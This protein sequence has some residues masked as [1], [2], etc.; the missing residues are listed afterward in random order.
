MK[1][2]EK[3]DLHAKSIAELQ[4]MLLDLKQE[5][6]TMNL[7]MAQRKLTN[8]RSRSLKKADVARVKTIIKEKYMLEEMQKETV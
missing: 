4:K 6:V 2:K 8:T 7:E 3:I 5:L 1:Q